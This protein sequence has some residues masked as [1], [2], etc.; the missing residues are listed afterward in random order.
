MKEIKMFMFDGCPHCRKAREIIA[1]LLE[2]EPEYKKINF[3]MIDEKIESEVADKY[4][5]YY[6]PAF[7]VGEKKMHEGKVDAEIIKKVFKAAAE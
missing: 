6:V 3:V 1:S 4:D 7:Y 5:Y 2:S